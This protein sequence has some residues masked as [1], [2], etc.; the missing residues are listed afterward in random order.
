M[1]QSS[2]HRG[3]GSIILYGHDLRLYVL[4]HGVIEVGQK[5]LHRWRY[6]ILI[7]VSYIIEARRSI[8]LCIAMKPEP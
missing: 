3:A 1:S 5:A 8:L 2:F 4:F 7:M 6:H